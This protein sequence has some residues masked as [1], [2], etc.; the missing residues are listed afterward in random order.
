[1][2]QEAQEAVSNILK[3]SFEEMK[4]FSVK[5]GPA[6]FDPEVGWIPID[7]PKKEQHE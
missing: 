2:N 6:Y 4:C 5:E 7:L 1:M 3:K